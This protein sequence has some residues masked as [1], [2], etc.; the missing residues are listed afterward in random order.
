MSLLFHWS[1]HQ[2][3][4]AYPPN[5][6]ELTTLITVTASE[7]EFSSEQIY[8]T[9]YANKTYFMLRNFFENKNISKK[10][11]LILRIQ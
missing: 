7:C 4:I 9:I 1:T 2:N 10:L 8:N 6:V 11:K 3:F 5:T